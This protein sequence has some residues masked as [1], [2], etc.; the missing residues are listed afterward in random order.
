ML[1]KKYT[2]EKDQVQITKNTHEFVLPKRKDEVE[3]KEIREEVFEI[4]QPVL[5]KIEELMEESL[6]V[7]KKQRHFDE[8]MKK[9]SGGERE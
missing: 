7:V 6:D 8:E 2:L 3:S 1:K 5:Q 4:V 9:R